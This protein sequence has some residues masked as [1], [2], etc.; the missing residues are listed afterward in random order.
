[1]RNL[2]LQQLPVRLP[3]GIMTAPS[4]SKPKIFPD[5]SSNVTSLQTCYSCDIPTP[6]ENEWLPGT[7]DSPTSVKLWHPTTN[8]SGVEW[9]VAV[10]NGGPHFERQWP[11]AHHGGTGEKALLITHHGGTYATENWLPVTSYRGMFAEEN[12][13]PV[14]DYGG[15]HIR[16]GW[17]PVTDHGGTYA[18]ENG[19][20][21][22]DYGGMFAEENGLPVTDYGGAHAK[23]NGLPAAHGN[24]EPVEMN[25]VCF[26]EEFVSVTSISGIFAGHEDVHSREGPVEK[27]EVCDVDTF[28]KHLRLRDLRF[29]CQ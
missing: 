24:E 27:I 25:E 12:G 5:Q 9:A 22:T 10:Y 18:G 28:V 8:S 14:T 16:E 7:C 2:Q 19:L 29:L 3:R 13:L 1:M 26:K 6:T 4:S 20:P 17:L 23:E 15:T 11:A 21:V